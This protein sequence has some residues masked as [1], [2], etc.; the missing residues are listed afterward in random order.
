MVTGNCRTPVLEQAPDMKHPIVNVD[1]SKSVDG[2]CWTVVKRWA[3][4]EVS[5]E[6]FADEESAKMHAL[7]LVGKTGCLVHIEGPDRS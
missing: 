7:S 5:R 4:E 3:G 2:A 1:P 6:R